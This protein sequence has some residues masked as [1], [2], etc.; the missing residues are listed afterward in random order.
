M[1]RPIIAL[2]LLVT[3]G[4]TAW[5]QDA[6]TVQF[7][8]PSVVRI[9]KGG[10]APAHSY[11]VTAQPQAV[12][13][14]TTAGKSGITYA[15][16]ALKVSV[17]PDGT[18]RFQDARGRLLL[19][20]GDWGFE[21]RSSGVDQGARIVRQTFLP[22]AGEPFY[23]LGILQD[24]ALNLRGKT[25]RMVQD[26]T[27]DFVNIVQSVRGYGLFWDNPSPT[28]FRDD[29]Q[30]M[31]FESEVGEVVDYY[32]IYGGS[33]DGVIAGIRA[34]TGRVPMLPLWSYGFMQCRERYRSSAELLGALR[35]YRERGVPLDCIIQ[36]WQYWGNNYLWNAMEFLNDDFRNAQAMIDEVH[37]RNAHLMISIWSSF[38]PMTR[39]F[40]ELQEQ[41]HLLDMGTWPRSG[42]PDWP[43]IME[44]PSGVRPYDPFSAEA[45]DLYWRYLSK[46]WEMGLD[47]WW[48]DST[49]PDHHSLRRRR[50]DDFELMTADGSLR[51]VRNAYPITAVEGVYDHQ[52]A[53]T[54]DRR[55]TILTR[56]AYAGQQRTGA[57]T[58]SGDVNSNWPTLRAQIPAGLGFALTG[59]PNFNTDCGGFF[60]GGYNRRG[61][62]ATC[63]QNPRFQELYVRWLQYGAFSP[64]MRSHG[65]SSRREIWEFGAP[66]EPVYD[67][68]ASTIRLR[69]KLMPYIYGTAWDV[70]ASDGTF[71]RALVMDFAADK[72]VWELPDEF[73]FGR[74]LLVAPVVK[75]QYTSEEVRWQDEPVDFSGERSTQVYLPKGTDWY[76]FW[77][78]E[79]LKGGQTLTRSTHLDTV[80]LYVRAGGIIPLG[81]DVQ[82]VSEKPWDALEVRVYPG[83]DGRFT[84]YED[85]GDGYAYEQ[86]ACS[87]IEFTLKGRTLTVGERRGSFPGMLRERTFRIVTPDGRSQEISYDGSS[88]SIKL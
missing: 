70:T 79:R 28:L 21:T 75:A 3:A 52:R 35:G 25:R 1:N 82:Y 54:S 5:A 83:A 69:Y 20:E 73:L 45:R 80:P 37:E 87:E 60:P 55:V 58:W 14:K 8:T 81:P 71:Q 84:L 10:P 61:A 86:G 59:N 18:V 19:K 16:A 13:V 72:A 78:G 56:S 74:S 48:M 23:G 34:L 43:P 22:E 15:S 53:A 50:D 47:A 51:R 40:R 68:I 9:V 46:M 4:L 63:A 76:D 6:V 32:F 38:G 11:A 30:G 57:N 42:L 24:G 2:L 12:A 44:Y 62:S 77:T 49:E 39:Q 17:A 31:L 85:E 26:N 33:A 7:Y 41:G 88:L 67:A 65:E 64:M 29:G 36:D 66:G 27:E